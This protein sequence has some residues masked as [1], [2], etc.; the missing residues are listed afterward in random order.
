MQNP[1]LGVWL[2]KK[3][4]V[5]FW[6]PKFQYHSNYNPP[7]DLFL[8]E[9]G[10]KAKRCYAAVNCCRHWRTLPLPP[11]AFPFAIP[12]EAVN[13]VGNEGEFS[14]ISQQAVMGGWD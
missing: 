8:R 11:E 3:F 2:V 10:V 4:S 9:Q 13:T 1:S 6:H 12:S 7:F 5:F 14:V